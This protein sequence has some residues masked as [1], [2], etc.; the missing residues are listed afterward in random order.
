MGAK[1]PEIHR[2]RRLV[3]NFNCAGRTAGLDATFFVPISKWGA[4]WPNG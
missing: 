4:R 1:K 3:G 2:T